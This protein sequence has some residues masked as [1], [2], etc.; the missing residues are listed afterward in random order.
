MADLS[1]ITLPDNTQVTLRDKSQERSDHRHFESDIV[2]LIHK[3]YESTSYYATTSGSWETSTWYFAS[4]KPDS[5][6]LPWKVKFKI[7]TYCPNYATHESLTYSMVSGRADSM[8]YCNWNEVNTTAHYYIAWYPL[9]L[10]GF[11]A[12]YGHAFGISIYNASSYANANY[13]RTFEIDYF[14]CENCTV[15]ILDTPVKYADW[16]G[17]GSTNY[18][19]L[20]SGNASSRGLQETGDNDTTTSNRIANFPGK[21]GAK[22]IWATSLF[23]EDANGTYENICTA[24][25]GTVT[26][27]NRTTA[28]TKKANT[29]GF[30]VLGTIYYTN[31]TYAANTNISGS[32]VIWS[33]Y[34]LFD[35]RLAF[36]TELT[37]TSLTPFKELY[38]VGTIHSDGLF[39][40]DSTWWTQTPNDTSKVYVLVGACWDS[41]T[42]YCR[43]TMYEQNKWYRYNGSQLIE[44]S[45]DAITV[46]G[47]TV[48]TD[49]PSG[50]IFTDT[51]N[52]AG[53]TDT[54]NKIYLIGATEQAANPQTYSDNEVYATSG[55]V[56]TK[57]VQVGGG[58][59]TM[60]YNTTTKAVD[61]IFT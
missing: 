51:K 56:T 27:S 42:S 57:S 52:T 33:A 31:T 30:K 35:S 36:N 41:S 26:S 49:V 4:I 6:Y 32:G 39:Y 5:W 17:G 34:G 38:L 47:H 10:A 45:N 28:T 40:L 20:A 53:S 25:D 55:V 59:A 19:S 9:K 18:G 60:Q 16:P 50:A 15:T 7:H 24:S 61:F 8:S 22:G 13:Y 46:N 23:M 54:S 1:K 37:T 14:G 43:I 44:I 58:A 29:T 3:K 48:A 11:D 21:T 2:P 12:G